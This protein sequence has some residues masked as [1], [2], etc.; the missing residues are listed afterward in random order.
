MTEN[1][2]KG[3]SINDIEGIKI[4]QAENKEAATGCTVIINE[5]GSPTG[6]DVRGGGP[7]SRESQV[8]KPTASTGVVHAIVLSGGSAFGLDAASG[9]MDYLEEHDIGFDV[10]VTKVPIVCQSSLFDLGVGDFKVRPDKD[11]GY[12]ACQNAQ[13]GGNYRD[14]NY[15]AGTGATVGKRYMMERAMKTGIGSYAVQLGELKVG[16]LVAVNALGDIF[17]YK[18][19]QKI[20][21]LLSEDKKTFASTEE[22]MLRDIKVVDNKFTGNT[23]I[24]AV[25]TNASFDKT[26]L[27]KIAAMASNGYAQSIRP[28]NTSADGDTVY[29]MSVGDVKADQDL[30]GTLATRVVSEAI[31]RAVESAES[32]YGFPCAADIKMQR[33]GK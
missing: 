5:P 2:L 7:A 30:V 14:G 22:D 20:G 4:G 6:V 12:L 9:V 3:I 15:G 8:L 32:A 29:A 16:A 1:I 13:N 28:V 25:I 10:L 24:G 26:Q 11:M 19:G 21:G 18:T 27:T 31:I 23:T 33:E 17:D